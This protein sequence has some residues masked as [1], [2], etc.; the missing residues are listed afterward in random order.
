MPIPKP[1]GVREA[2]RN[3]VCIVLYIAKVDEAVG[4][5]KIPYSEQDGIMFYVLRPRV[6]E[7]VVVSLDS[8]TRRVTSS[9]KY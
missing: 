4:Y 3:Y 8:E 2:R 7:Q 6:V 5:R 9:A 1:D